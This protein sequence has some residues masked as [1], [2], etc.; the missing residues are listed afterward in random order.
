MS[1]LAQ[2]PPWPLHVV[3]V[4]ALPSSRRGTVAEFRHQGVVLSRQIDPMAALREIGRE[5]RS[6]VVVNATLP[7]TDAGDF[8]EIVASLAHS[9]VLLG[10]NP[11]IPDEAIAELLKRGA[12]GSVPLPLTP[13]R[14]AAALTPT[15]QARVAA[16]VES[17]LQCGPITVSTEA[18]RVF[19]GATEVA[20]SPKE[21]DVLTYLMRAFPRL[22]GVDE[23][24][25][26][27]AD[28][29]TEPETRMRLAVY[30]TRVKLG[31]A[32]PQRGPLIQTVRGM[33]YRL[34]EQ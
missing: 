1:V 12:A 11:E 9:T 32:A 29:H 26:E 7:D 30:R 13:S 5:P 18:H 31:E 8:I 21:F 28:G 16:P 27:F 2:P 15:A 22:V 20:L 14:L 23:L 33:G 25:G 19:V 10:V 17:E 4:G 6:V 24:V 3:L 34:V